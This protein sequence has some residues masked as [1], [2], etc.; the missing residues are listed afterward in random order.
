M[1]KKQ[2]EEQVYRI[3]ELSNLAGVTV[4]TIRYYEELGLLDSLERRE[5]GHRRYT[6]HDLL[7]LKRIIQ[8][9]SYGLSLSEI[10]EIIE[11]SREDP[12][13]EKRRQKLLERYR[14]KLSEAKER[15]A[16]LDAYIHE[17]EWHIDQLENVENFLACPGEECK[18]CKYVEICRF[19]Q[20]DK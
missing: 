12:T 14:E 13:G 19:A 16:R 11:L 15:R 20:I 18:K 8:L 9:K 6:E 17:L 2:K 3:G 1:Y 5:S 4:R 10:S 7:H